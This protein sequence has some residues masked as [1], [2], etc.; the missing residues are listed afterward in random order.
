M[1]IPR[2]IRNCNP[3]NIRLGQSWQGMAAMQTDP[4]FVQFLS[5]EYGIRAIAKIMLTYASNGID[6]ISGIINR[7]APPSENDTGAYVQAVA[8]Q[9]SVA[10]TDAVDMKSVLPGLVRA[11]IQH[12]NGEQPYTDE[13]INAGIAMAIEPQTI[14][15]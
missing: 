2:G 8:E 6:T 13:Q 12:E 1:S 10:P 9:C 15:T 5:P 3:G 7:W 4:S 11:I 14:S